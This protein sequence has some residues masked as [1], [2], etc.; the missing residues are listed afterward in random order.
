MDR[1]P[2]PHSD[3]K[4]K[5]GGGMPRFEP[6]RQDREQVLLMVGYGLTHEEIAT[7]IKN[8]RT[9]EPISV[10]TLKRTMSAEL[11]DGLAF[12][13]TRVIGNLVKRACSDHPSAVG[14]AI[15]LTKARFG[16]KSTDRYEHVHEGT[17]GVLVAPA[18]QSPGTWI[19]LQQKA[20]S[21]RKAPVPA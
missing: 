10:N 9:G 3:G 17:T 11:R 19:G 5:R 4:K 13:K 20:N 18:A 8:P 21:K 15:W 12:I 7:L 6:T 1:R 2:E 16:W 14:A